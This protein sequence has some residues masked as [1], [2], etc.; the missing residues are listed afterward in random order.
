MKKDEMI[1]VSM[2]L[3]NIYEEIFES[4]N[5]KENTIFFEIGGNS[6]LAAKVVQKIK[7]CFGVNLALQD[8][9]EY[10]TIEL[11]SAQIHKMMNTNEEPNSK[12]EIYYADESGEAFE[13]TEIQKAYLI[14]R[15]NI[16]GEGK[17]ASHYYVEIECKDINIHR[18]NGAWN[19][20]IANQEVLRTIIDEE[21][22]KQKVLINV[23]A[24]KIQILDFSD[25][26]SSFYDLRHEMESQILD[27]SKWPVFDIRISRIKGKLQLHISMDNIIL[28]GTSI[29]A[30]LDEWKQLYEGEL[31]SQKIKKKTFKD[32]VNYLGELRKTDEYREAKKYWMKKILGLP[33]RPELPLLNE[34][35]NG[36]FYRLSTVISAEKW[37]IIKKISAEYG[38]TPS[39]ALLSSFSEVLYRWGKESQFAINVTVN[40]KV[41]LG[42]EYAETLGEFTDT[43][44]I[45]VK[46]GSKRSFAEKCKSIQKELLE[47]LRYSAYEGV[48]IQRDWS[49]EHNTLFGTAFPVVFTSLL[50]ASD[51]LEMPGK[52]SYGL[53]QTPQVWLDYQVSENKG[54]LYLNWDLLQGKYDKDVISEMFSSY[55]ESIENLM[56]RQFWNAEIR[57]HIGHFQSSLPDEKKDNGLIKDE[58]LYKGFERN[59]IKTP[60]KVAIATLNAQYT[61]QECYKKAVEIGKYINGKKTVGIFMDKGIMQIISI[62]AASMVSATYVPIDINNPKERIGAILEEASVE[63]VLTSQKYISILKEATCQKVCVDLLKKQIEQK[64]IEEKIDNNN[65]YI[66]FT[67]GTTGTPKGVVIKHSSA[68]NTILD[69]NKRFK[70]DD[71]DIILG[72][73]NISFDLSVFDIFGTFSAGGTL[74]L[75]EESGVKDPKEWIELIETKSVT[76]CNMVPM[77]MEMLCTY[78][79]KN[80]ISMDRLKSVRLVLLSGDKIPLELPD[81]IHLIIPD[82]RV[83]CLGGATEASIWS[84]YY[85]PREINKKWFSIPYG[86]PLSNQKYYV[87]NKEGLICPDYVEGELCIAGEGLAEEYIND[88]ALTETK[89]PF[90]EEINRRIYKT[91][92]RGVCIRGC[93]WYLGREDTQIK[94]R[95]YRIELGEIESTLNEVAGIEMTKAVYKDDKLLLFVLL[96]QD[97]FYKV[98]DIKA[99]LEKKLPQFYMPDSI[100][101][102]DEFPENRNGKIDTAK[103][104][105]FAVDQP[106]REKKLEDDIEK[107]IAEIWEQILGIKEHKGYDMDFFQ[108]GG[109]S[110]KAVE[111]VAEMNHMYQGIELEIKDLFLNPTISQIGVKIKAELEKNM[112]VE[113]GTI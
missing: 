80:G 100:M 3:Q 110:L 76:V 84:N 17:V 64:V 104:Y 1:D 43:T 28:D 24:Y 20:V 65:A 98:D 101:I 111:V 19:T 74:V 109:D 96:N 7:K 37:S 82:A 12:K 25:D 59:F 67:S 21:N 60:D 44:L 85:E 87:L 91:G 107:Q 15:Q 102:L 78:V 16:T 55:L 62:L 99:I 63:V 31:F 70:I 86:Y 41:L 75:P 90:N 69:I 6:I 34:N 45:E 83:I 108:C 92:D 23:P 22:M 8:I 46:A 73:S 49:K 10:P 72:L 13:L 11:L 4:S 94:R 48:K 71:S 47:N 38:I 106:E 88:K 18:L 39:N 97:S 30:V 29:C 40:R 54:Q 26:I 51:S 33:S 14:G 9:F 52:I 95:G 35:V 50:G 68:N 57:N 77:R 56:D 5:I 93:I 61:Y 27:V 36:K 112:A 79:I 113:K 2:K 42:S 89:F 53:T 58:P 81:R 32:Y 66:I 103:L 105:R